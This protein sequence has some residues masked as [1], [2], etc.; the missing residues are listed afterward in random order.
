MRKYFCVVNALALILIAGCDMATNNK[1]DSSKN[2]EGRLKNE[3]ICHTSEDFIQALQSYISGQ[4]IRL[5]PGTYQ[6]TET[7]E[8]KKNVSIVGEKA[9][10]TDEKIII[11]GRI[12]KDEINIPLLQI[13]TEQAIFT[14]LTIKN[15]V[16]ITVNSYSQSDGFKNGAPFTL[17]LMAGSAKLE[18]CFIDAGDA[19]AILVSKDT[20]LAM[21]NCT[22]EHCLTAIQLEN[23]ASFFIKECDIAHSESGMLFRSGVNGSIV[24]CRISE[25]AEGVVFHHGNEE[26]V[27]GMNVILDNCDISKMINNGLVIYGNFTPVVKNCRIHHCTSSGVT[28]TSDPP[29]PNC[30]AIFENCIRLSPEINGQVLMCKC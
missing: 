26:M 15:I 4:T 10:D 8:I 12:T 25:G 24:D 20:H 5:Y 7:I 28:V 2:Q 18:N 17:K 22:L 13:N 14:N 29:N 1:V 6:L 16:D 3:W 21:E 27:E 9:D 11:E 30:H 19:F 23:S